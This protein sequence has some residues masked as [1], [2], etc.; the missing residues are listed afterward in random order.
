M[1]QRAW[2][3][4]GPMAWALW[5]LSLLYGAL[6]AAR[7]G[8]YR[9]GILKSE[10]PGRP[11]IVVGNVIAGGAGK[12]PVTMALVQHLRAQ[13]TAS[14]VVSHYLQLIEQL[15]PDAVLRLDQG[16]IAQSGGLELAREIA[17]SGFGPKATAPSTAPTAAAHTVEA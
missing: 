9:A 8:L 15:Q 1:L 13:G 5:P 17:R 14:I 10:H 4:R 7:R 12:T 11:V 2:Q 6:T 3:T 16:C